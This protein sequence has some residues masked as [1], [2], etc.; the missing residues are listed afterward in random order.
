MSQNKFLITFAGAVGSSKTPIA[1][2]LSWK[3]GIPI[4]NNDAIRTEVMED[5]GFF[6]EEEYKKRRDSRIQ[7]LL[8]KS[9]SLIFDSSI[10]REWVNY[11]QAI[12]AA[13]YKTFIIN[14]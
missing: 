3:L 4:I 9:T 6:D 13:K 11:E 14:S 2:Y 10:D 8:K 12:N 5:V 7:E 1:Y